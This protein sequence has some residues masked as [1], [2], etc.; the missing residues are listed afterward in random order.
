MSSAT[1]TTITPAQRQAIARRAM[2]ATTPYW[3]MKQELDRAALAAETARIIARRRR[4]PAAL[5]DARVA[6]AEYGVAV[7]VYM[8]AWKEWPEALEEKKR[9]GLPYAD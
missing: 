2:M 1:P 5:A 4:S 8:P 7:R 6:L 9:A 3:M